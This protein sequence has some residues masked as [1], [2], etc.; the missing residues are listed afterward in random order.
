MI[1]GDQGGE[2]SSKWQEVLPKLAVFT[3]VYLGHQYIKGAITN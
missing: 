2:Q 3:D 1:L